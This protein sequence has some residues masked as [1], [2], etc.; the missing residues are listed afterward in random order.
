MTGV[1]NI[2]VENLNVPGI[3]VL[4]LYCLLALP[5]LFAWNLL[6]LCG[7]SCT[8]TAPNLGLLAAFSSL[9]L[10]GLPQKP[11]LPLASLGPVVP[12]LHM[13]ASPDDSHAQLRVACGFLQFGSHRSGEQMVGS[14]G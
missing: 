4:F 11:T 13:P 7:I 10:G 5:V 12:G 8:C 2:L 14:G 6:G 1:F 3:L 9:S